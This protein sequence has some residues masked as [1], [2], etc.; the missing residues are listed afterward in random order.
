VDVLHVPPAEPDASV[1][2]PTVE[3]TGPAP[4]SSDVRPAQAPAP[5]SAS[6]LR[7]A[8]AASAVVAAAGVAMITLPG[9]PS[10]S[11]AAAASTTAPAAAAPDTAAPTAAPTVTS[12]A[13]PPASPATITVHVE[14][15][16]PGAL[17]SIDGAHVGRT[18][19]DAPL[20]RGATAAEVVLALPGF[21]PLRTRVVP[22]VD[23]RMLL[24]LQPAPRA[25]HR[26]ATRPTAPRVE[27]LP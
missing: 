23:Q 1:E 4:T 9:A 16:P 12:A 17:V 11:E 20:P 15:T 8:A 25:A 18:P 26:P 7:W 10:R 21:Q 24:T 3:R 13:D 5:S 2:L 27:K 14:S 19:L 6:W 22:D